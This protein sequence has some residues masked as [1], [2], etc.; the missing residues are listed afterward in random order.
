MRDKAGKSNNQTRM[1]GFATSWVAQLAAFA[2]ASAFLFNLR[3]SIGHA[4]FSAVLNAVII[5]LLAQV[6]TVEKDGQVT[7]FKLPPKSKSKQEL[8]TE[9]ESSGS[10]IWVLYLALVAALNA[11]LFNLRISTG[12]AT[13]A[14]VLNGVVVGILARVLTMGTSEWRVAV[15][16]SKTSSEASSDASSDAEDAFVEDPH[17]LYKWGQAAVALVLFGVFLMF[18]P[19]ADMMQHSTYRW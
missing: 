10:Q 3:V 19:V 8:G 14:A 5:G 1:A 4:L 7:A 15:Q 2:A 16:K 9:P 11:F 17:H 18:V 13:L 6:L 12:H